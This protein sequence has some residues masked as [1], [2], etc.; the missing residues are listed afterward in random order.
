MLEEPTDRVVV[1]YNMKKL[2][3]LPDEAPTFCVSLNMSDRID[4]SGVHRSFEFDH[5]V[6]TPEA[7]EAQGRWSEISGHN[8][9]HFCGAYWRN[10]FHED[11]VVSGMAV[12]RTLGAGI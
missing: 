8:R 2:Q 12:A 3:R 10:G 6:F 4:P 7:V 1:T 9:T 11:G 5:P